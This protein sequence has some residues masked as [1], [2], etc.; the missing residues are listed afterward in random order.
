MA[1]ASSLG[2]YVSLRALQGGGVPGPVPFSWQPCS[3]QFSSGFLIFSIFRDFGGGL[4]GNSFG[5]PHVRF[6]KKSRKK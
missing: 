6:P 3:S 2:L 5:V 1:P 4:G